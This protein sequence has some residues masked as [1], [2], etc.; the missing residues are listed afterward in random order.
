MVATS[1]CEGALLPGTGANRVRASNCTDQKG[2]KRITTNK[3]DISQ[4]HRETLT[5]CFTNQASHTR[6]NKQTS[7]RNKHPKVAKVKWAAQ[8][9]IRH[10]FGKG[11]V[12]SPSGWSFKPVQEELGKNHTRQLDSSHN[13]RSKT[14]IYFHT[15]PPS[16]T[17]TTAGSREGPSLIRRGDQII[18]EKSNCTSNRGWNRFCQSSL[19]CTQGRRSVAPSDKSQ[20]TKS[21]CNSAT[22]Q[23]GINQNSKIPNSKGRLAHKTRPEGC[24]SISSSEP[25]LPKV[26]Q[27]PLAGPVVAIHSPPI[28]TKQCT[29]YFHQIN[30]T[31]YSDPEETGNSDGLVPGQYDSNGKL[32]GKGQGTL[33]IS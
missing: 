25:L 28:W 30:E 31:S 27:I 7:S 14:G 13:S 21:L 19:C 26:P 3:G 15:T 5:P 32:S 8:L 12:S 6:T 33:S 4:P 9:G 17:P 16:D 22:L 1:F 24:L 29:L 20:G 23:D 11:N 18:P 2:T 10:G